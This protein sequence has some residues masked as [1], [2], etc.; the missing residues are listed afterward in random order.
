MNSLIFES[1][2]LVDKIE[3]SLYFL[4]VKTVKITG[5]F[6]KM[7]KER[8]KRLSC[9]YEYCIIILYRYIWKV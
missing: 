3:K 8:R 1:G 5:N 9:A 6:M 4:F 7:K 2:F